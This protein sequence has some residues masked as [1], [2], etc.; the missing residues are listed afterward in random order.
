MS[1]TCSYR[2]L[3][4]FNTLEQ[5]NETSIYVATLLL[6]NNMNLKMQKDKA[7]YMGW[8]TIGLIVITV[9]GN[10]MFSMKISCGEFWTDK[11]L[12]AVQVKLEQIKNERRQ[13]KD[14]VINKFPNQSQYYQNAVEEEKA[15]EFLKT[16]NK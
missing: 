11:R 4:K 5:L 3:R 16:W 14:Q 6:L 8:V 15:I 13:L 7:A 2:P 1:Y 9:L 12:K 10:L